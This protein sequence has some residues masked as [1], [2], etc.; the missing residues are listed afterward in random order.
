MRVTVI[1][2]GLAGCEA[3]WQLARRGIDVTLVEQKPIART[4]AQSTDNLC[5]LVCSNSMRGAALVNAVGLLKEEL[6]RAGSLVLAC[7]EESKVPAGGALAVDREKF[8]ALVTAKIH[9]SARITLEHRVIDRIPDATAENP[10]ILATGPLTG[11]ALAADLARAVGAEHLAYYDAIAPI[12]AADSIDESKVFR[13]SRWGKG[14]DEEADD[15]A[16]RDATALGDEAYVNCPFDEA[17]YKAFVAAVV[18]AEKV[19]PRA[20][21]QTRYFEGCLPIEVMAAR[22]EMTLAF[23]PMKPVGLTDPRTGRRPFAVVQLR[24]E[25]FAATA[26]N[27]VGFQTRMTYGEQ[28]RVFR[29]IP[30]LEECEIQ[31]FGSVHRNTFVNAPVLLDERMQLRGRPHVYL[32]GQ[33]TGVEGYVESCAGGLLCGLMLAQW[34]ANGTI[35]PPP[36]ET[37][38]GGIR[39]HL[40]R[41]QPS[42]QPSNITWACMPPHEN[43]KLKKRDRYAALSERALVAIDAWLKTAPLAAL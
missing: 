33:I 42:Y 41:P 21:E 40:A 31:R 13:Q 22:G 19:E 12:I 35:A 27:L 30:G 18:A 38:L 6:R 17:G 11:D 16:P 14:G 24:Q 1:G 36:P 7:A 32:A 37:A 20:F 29:M 43:R 2:G 9:G 26:Y 4:P 39:T 34:H 25:D 23:G 28:A 10:V 8:A 3:A 5:E 15:G